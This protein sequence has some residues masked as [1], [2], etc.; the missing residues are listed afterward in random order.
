VVAIAYVSS[1]FLVSNINKP[2]DLNV[3]IG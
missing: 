3:R 2:L 1:F